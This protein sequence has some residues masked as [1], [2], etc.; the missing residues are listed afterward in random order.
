MKKNVLTPICCSALLLLSQFESKAQLKLI[1][2]WNFNATAPCAGTGGT[3]LSPITADYSTL[4][5]QLVYNQVLTPVRDSILDNGSGG[6]TVNRRTI[7][8]TD[9]TTACGQNL[10]VRTRNPSSETVF[11]WNIPTTHYK[12]ILVTYAAERSGSGPLTHVY[13]YSLDGI[14]FIT[15]GLSG[16]G[17]TLPDSNT[18]ATTWGQLQLDFSS[19]AGANNNPNFVLRVQTSQQNATQNGNDRYDNITVEG[20]TSIVSGIAEINANNGGYTLFP[21]PSKDNLFVSGSFEGTKTISIYNAMGQMVYT[22]EQTKKQVPI[23]TSQLENG[24]YFITIKEINGK[25]PVTLK[26]IKS[27]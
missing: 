12:N 3:N 23:S 17:T 16:M 24:M 26:F 6:S 10:Y 19:I 7:L 20:D 9:D 2:Y 8:G 15:T 18:V 25:I 1:H 22:T 14:N 21:N 13:S 5:A 11:L 4:G 27:N